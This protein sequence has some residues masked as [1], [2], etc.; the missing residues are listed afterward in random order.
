MALA[1]QNNHSV[2]LLAL[3]L[4]NRHDL[5]AVRIIGTIHDQILRKGYIDGLSGL[6]VRLV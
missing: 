3:R 2:E 1:A 4:V 5:N 6:C